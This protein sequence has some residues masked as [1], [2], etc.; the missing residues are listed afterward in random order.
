MKNNIY[1]KHSDSKIIVSADVFNTKSLLFLNPTNN[2]D[3][4]VC[5]TKYNDVSDALLS[6]DF[7]V[8]DDNSFTKRELELLLNS[9]YYFKTINVVTHNELT[10]LMHKL[11]TLLRTNVYLPDDEN[12]IIK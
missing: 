9:L 1:L 5:M 2:V 6:G 4:M 10:E 7:I 8:L 11:L 3:D 12:E